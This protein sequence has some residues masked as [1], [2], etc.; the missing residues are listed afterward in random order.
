MNNRG[1]VYP[2]P[3]LY[4]LPSGYSYY[5]TNDL[6]NPWVVRGTGTYPVS[7]IT[8]IDYDDYPGGFDVGET[9]QLKPV[10]TT[11][12]F[13][14]G[15]NTIVIFT[16]SDESVVKVDQNGLITAVGLGRAGNFRKSIPR[17]GGNR[18]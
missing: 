9:Y 4:T 2:L 13:D 6:E 17:H 1:E 8:S 10:L 11:E 14:S 16:S 15:L 5:P 18:Y 12:G 7:I 3:T